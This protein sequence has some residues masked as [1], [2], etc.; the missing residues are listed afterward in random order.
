M[1]A[2]MV[3]SIFMAKSAST[4]PKPALG[5]VVSTVSG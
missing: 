3:N 4:A 1:R 2:M 5:K